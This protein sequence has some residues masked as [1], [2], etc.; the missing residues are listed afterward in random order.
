M[1]NE[2]KYHNPE[3][4]WK[5]AQLIS[6]I[7]S[8]VVTV[9]VVPWGVWVTGQIF[10]MQKN[11]AMTQ[12]WQDTAPRYTEKDAALSRAVTEK[13]FNERIDQKLDVMMEMLRKHAAEDKK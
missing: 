1:S 10:T 7:C 2:P 12:A 11:Q 8:L 3:T 13:S 6:V 5:V 4:I 9:I